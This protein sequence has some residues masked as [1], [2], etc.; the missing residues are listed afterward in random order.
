MLV[1]NPMC[2]SLSWLRV[3]PGEERHEEVNQWTFLQGCRSE[4]CFSKEPG[5]PPVNL[6][7]SPYPSGM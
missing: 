6:G 5:S 2:R 3:D 7:F 4:F 1:S